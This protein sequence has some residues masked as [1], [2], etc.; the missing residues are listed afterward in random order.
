MK[1]NL[2]REIQLW[3]KLATNEYN[4]RMIRKIE[5]IDKEFIYTISMDNFIFTIESIFNLLKNTD[6][7]VLQVASDRFCD[8]GHIIYYEKDH[9]EYAVYICLPQPLIA[10]GDLEKLQQWRDKNL[11]LK[12]KS[13]DFWNETEEL[14]NRLKPIYNSYYTRCRKCFGVHPR[15]KKCSR[16]SNLKFDNEKDLRKEL[17]MLRMLVV[18]K[19]INDDSWRI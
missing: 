16:C 7:D 11:Y 19:E 2:Y 10:L 4:S 14:W 6:V 9:K 12:E 5:N 1:N 18:L 13:N 15:E 3:I 17:G 8:K